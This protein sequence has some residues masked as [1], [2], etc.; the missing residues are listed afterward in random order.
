MPACWKTLFRREN[1]NDKSLIRMLTLKS[2][3]HVVSALLCS[4]VALNV[5]GLGQ[6]SFFVT[7]CTLVQKCAEVCALKT[8]NLV[9]F[10]RSK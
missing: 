10:D 5:A 1:A 9:L 6:V 7:V 4:L 3:F 8:T 2:N